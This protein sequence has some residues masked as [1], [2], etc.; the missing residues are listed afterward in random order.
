MAHSRA[1]WA[2]FAEMG[3]LEAGSGMS[4]RRKIRHFREAETHPLCYFDEA[5]F[6][7]YTGGGCG[8]EITCG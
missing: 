8:R 1:R 2:R 6:L 5:G 3:N 4:D 7:E